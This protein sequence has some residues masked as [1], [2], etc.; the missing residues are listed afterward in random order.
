MHDN[1]TVAISTNYV[2]C[3]KERRPRRERGLW[4]PRDRVLGTVM[5]FKKS[6]ESLYD[7]H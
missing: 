6:R 1:G 7:A 4:P 3:I 2:T 5:R